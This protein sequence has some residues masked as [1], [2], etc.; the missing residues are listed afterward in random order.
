MIVPG[1]TR[2]LKVEVIVSG[3]DVPGVEDLITAAGA[4]GYTTVPGVSGLGHAGYHQARLLFN[5]TDSLALL[6]TVV[7]EAVGQELIAGLTQ[8]LHASPGVML[9]S[10]TYVSRPEYFA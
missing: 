3:T 6:M 8:L 7:P 10:E 9:V 2:M 1:L 5:D 4:T